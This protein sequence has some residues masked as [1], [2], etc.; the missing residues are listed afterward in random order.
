MPVKS[1]VKNCP[2]CRHVYE[3]RSYVAQSRTPADEDRWLFGSP[4]K[5]CPNCHK[6]FV[7]QDMQELAITRPR[8]R[9]TVLI[10]AS[11]VKI[12]LIGAVLGAGLI[13]LAHQTELGLIAFGVA[14]ATVIADLALYP[15]RMKKL[16]REREAS[17]KRLSNP[18]YARMLQK[19]GY[20]V[21]E[22]Y[23]KQEDRHDLRPDGTPGPV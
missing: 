14:L 10:N 20:H 9:D 23:L 8:K 11:T 12:A 13:F 5:M 16:E 2:Y 4:M 3:Q 19:A 22:K 7:D 15:N 1:L 17:E 21:P 18:D 6:M